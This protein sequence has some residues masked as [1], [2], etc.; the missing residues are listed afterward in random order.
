MGIPFYKYQGTGND[1]IIVDNREGQC[2]FSAQAIAHWCH[3]RF[4]IG[5]DG[6]MLLGSATGFDFS[7]TYYNADGAP[8]TMCGN[9]GRCLVQFAHDRGIVKER[10]RFI[11]VDGEHQAFLDQQNWVHLEMIPVQNIQSQ[12]EAFVLHT[13]SPHY[14][15]PA[16][17]PLAQM[18]VVTA[19]RALRNSPAFKAEG[20]NVNFVE[21]Q[22]D[23]LFVRTYERG[24][25][26]ETYSCGTGVTAAALA[27]ASPALGPNSQ[28]ILTL[29]GPLQ[30]SY[31]QT[32]P[33]H[34]TD[35]WLAGPAEFVF[36]GILNPGLA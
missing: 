26:D 1:F 35:V 32:A 8:S 25:E 2:A 18:D 33:G 14:V 22:D 5:A 29:G 9:G 28:S 19:G 34:F 21:K 12:G 31:H 13:G 4:G 7:M 20:I 15:A 16:P 10:Y 17:A 3:R 24:V 36:Q 23:R 30:V 11:A 27:F 6:F